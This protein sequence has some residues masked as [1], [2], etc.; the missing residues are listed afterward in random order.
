MSR[1]TTSLELRPLLSS[2]Q[3]SAILGVTVGTVAKWR[4]DGTGPKFIKVSKYVVYDPNDITDWLNARRVSST[5]DG[6]AVINTN[7]EQN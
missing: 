6:A 4:I 3:V 7:K 2:K 1:E 5:R